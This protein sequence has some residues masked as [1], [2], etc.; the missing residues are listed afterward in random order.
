MIVAY[1]QYRKGLK[2]PGLFQEMIR[3]GFSVDMCTL[4][5][6]STAFTCVEDL[7]G[8]LQFH[9]KLGTDRDKIPFNILYIVNFDIN[10]RKGFS[11]LLGLIN[12][13]Q[14]GL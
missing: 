13:I 9:D 12:R 2:A 7:L 1:G 8:G 11:K 14:Q 5:S 6:V 4:A 3:K 10:V